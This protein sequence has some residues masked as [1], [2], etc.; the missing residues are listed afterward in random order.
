M[1]YVKVYIYLKWIIY[2]SFLKVEIWYVFYGLLILGKNGIECYCKMVFFY[3][4]K[5][6]C[7]LK[8]FRYISSVGFILIWLIVV[9]IFG[10]SFGIVRIGV[11]FGW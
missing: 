6:D 4:V 5:N 3:L 9:L 7:F 8:V 11:L 2:F 10:F 1:V